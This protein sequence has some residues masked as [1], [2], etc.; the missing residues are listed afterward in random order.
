MQQITDWLN[1]LGLSEYAQR[2]ADNGID[3]SVLLDLTDQ[4]WRSSA[5]S[6]AIVGKCC[7]RLLTWTP[8]RLRRLLL[9][10]WRLHRHRRRRLLCRPRKLLAGGFSCGL[11]SGCR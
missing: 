6:W 4:I 9:S 3:L 11:L 5:S 2:F 10:C 7:V 8:C 1:T